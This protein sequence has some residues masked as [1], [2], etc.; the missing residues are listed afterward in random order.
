MIDWTSLLDAYHVTYRDRGPNVGKD[1]IVVA[2]PFCGPADPGEH[3]S[4]S[5]QGK[6]WRCYRDSEHRGISPTRLIQALTGCDWQTAQ[7]LGGHSGPSLP[8]LRGI[9]DTVRAMLAGDNTEQPLPP[10]D[11]APY[12]LRSLADLSPMAN[13][14]RSYML[15]RGFNPDD[16]DRFGVA[17]AYKGEQLGRIVFVLTDPASMQPVGLTGRTISQREQR[18]YYASGMVDAV[19]P[20]ASLFP[21]AADTLLLCEGPMDALKVNVLG[22]HAGIYATCAMTSSFS[23]RQLGMVVEILPRFR[24]RLIAFDQGNEASAYR[25]SYHLPG[26]FERVPLPATAKDPGEVSDLN[27][28]RG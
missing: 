12:H 27:W 14:Y 8:A 2:C 10:F 18:R 11:L 6:G 19:L 16:L 26:R 28:L 5:L 25:L 17:Y 13:P 21:P 23:P 15:S 1:H 24:R 20:F 9:G 3:L 22:N 7:R 4:I